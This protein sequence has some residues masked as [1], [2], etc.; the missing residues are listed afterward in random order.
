MA[1]MRGRAGVVRRRR[2]VDGAFKCRASRRRTRHIEREGATLAD[3]A[4]RV[5]T[6]VREAVALIGMGRPAAESNDERIARLRSR[7]IYQVGPERGKD[8]SVPRTSVPPLRLHA[9]TRLTAAASRVRSL[10]EDAIA[11]A[12]RWPRVAGGAAR[13]AAGVLVFRVRRFV[14][15]V[16]AVVG[17]S[18]LV[19]ILAG[20]LWALTARLTRPDTFPRMHGSASTHATRQAERPSATPAKSAA[21][22]LTNVPPPRTQPASAVAAST[23]RPR[24]T[25]EGAGGK[26]STGG[27]RSQNRINPDAV[28]ADSYRVDGTVATTGQTPSGTPARKGSTLTT[29]SGCVTPNADGRKTFTLVDATGGETYIL[30]GMDTRTSVGK[31][32]QVTGTLAKRIRIADRL[33]PSP[34]VAAKAGAIDPGHAALAAQSQSNAQSSRP[35]IE[36]NVKSVRLVPG[37]CPAQ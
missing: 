24:P 28:L 30:N 21:S 9:I 15:P 11:A 8:P 10:S 27:A 16:V 22:L 19:A 36:V 29:L 17:L 18:A 12:A 20:G 14:R 1:D 37:S 31:Q 2:P 13:S 33:Y 34:N 32:M 35:A 25:L 23:C 4:R 6:T 3:A 5:R 26:A 7:L